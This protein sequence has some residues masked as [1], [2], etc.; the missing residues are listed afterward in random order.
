MI[1][2]LNGVEAAALEPVPLFFLKYFTTIV[3]Y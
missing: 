1:L 2:I 3:P